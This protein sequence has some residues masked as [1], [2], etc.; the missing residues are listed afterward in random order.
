MKPTPA[1]QRVDLDEILFRTRN[2]AYGAYALR[3]ALPSTT[4]RAF[5][6]TVVTAV[7]AIGLPTWL[8]P[9]APPALTRGP[10]VA[11]FYDGPLP[12]RPRTPP[13]P[14]S[15]AAPP[16]PIRTMANQPPTPTPDAQVPAE[17]TIR[18][19]QERD[20]TSADLGAR[21]TPGA[22]HGA[23]SGVPGGTGDPTPTEVAEPAEPTPF[24]LFDG[25]EPLALNLDEVKGDVRYPRAAVEAGIEGTV[26]L[27]VLVGSD[28]A[29]VRHVVL[30]EA[31]P[32]L[33]AEVERQVRQLRFRPGLQANR[34]VKVWVT[35][36]FRFKIR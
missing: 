36:P 2:R 34:P 17:N 3:R 23:P 20:T 7:L 33:R 22:D 14:P 27:R 19:N 5:A 24:E 6:A 30:R 28:G 29:Y 12:E 8:R 4:A 26:V 31:H 35:L 16:A 11:D 1:P 13:K 21:D 18:T 15:A 32:L 10:V 25:V 9:A